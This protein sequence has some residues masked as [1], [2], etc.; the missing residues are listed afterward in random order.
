MSADQNLPASTPTKKPTAPSSNHRLYRKML[1]TDYADN[2]NIGAPRDLPLFLFL[3]IRSI[4]V[5]RGAVDDFY[6]LW[7]WILHQIALRSARGFFN[8]SGSV[9]WLGT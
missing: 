8:F 3:Y 9:A 1:T 4:R 7:D 2:A 5:I 6:C